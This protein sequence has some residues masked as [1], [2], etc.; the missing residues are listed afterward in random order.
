M[1]EALWA[2]I[3]ELRMAGVT[4]AD[5]PPAAFVNADKHAELSALLAATRRTWPIATSPTRPTSTARRSRH[6]DVW[7]VLA[8]D[9][10]IELPGVIW[11]PLERRLL[12]ALPGTRVTPR[13]LELPGLPPIVEPGGAC[14]APAPRSR[15][16]AAGLS[17]AARRGAGPASDGTLTMFRAGGREAEV[18][19]VLR[20]VLR[21][22]RPLDHVEIACARPSTWRWCGRRRSATSGRSRS[23]PACRSRSRGRRGRCWRSATGSRAGSRPARCG[24]CS[25]RA[26]CGS[27]W[28]MAPAPGRRRGSWRERRRRGDGRPTRRRS[29]AWRRRPGRGRGRGDGR[30][31]RQ[32]LRERA[33]Q[34]ERLA[35]WLDGLLRS[36]PEVRDDAIR[37]VA[38]STPHRLRADVAAQGERAGRRGRRRARRGAGVAAGAR[39]PRAVAAG[40]ARRWSATAST[41]SPS[42]A[43]ARGPGIS[44]SRRCAT[45]ATRAPAHL[46]HRARGRARV[47]GAAGGPVLLDA[48]R[49]ALDPGA[50]DLAGSRERGAPPRRLAAGRAGRPRL[51]ELFVSRSAR[52]PRDVS[53]L[54]D[55]AGGAP[56]EA[57]ARL[58]VRREL[59]DELGEPVSAVP[60]TAEQAL[61]D[62]GLVARPRPRAGRSALP[63]VRAAFP[64]AGAGR[65]GR[66][67]ARVG[68]LHRLRRLRARGGAAARSARVR[69]RRVGDGARGP[70]RSARSAT[71]CSAGSASTRSRTPSRI[72]DAGSIR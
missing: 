29:P 60:A 52:A 32:R 31:E 20:R 65:G 50:A 13:A 14:R 68:R 3:A 19:E 33:G 7:P 69:P 11:S 71:S 24:G 59:D 18:E 38:G 36:V 40:G 27:T 17:A 12:D 43:T 4:A 56:A 10:R 70:G 67:R 34:A 9:L 16:G 49:E 55:A 66:G 62:D 54:A 2:T 35:Q 26:T 53:L 8:G 47:P 44:T 63:A 58:D 51:P 22:G 5:L 37:W 64:C 46:R 72:R 28:T 15:R 42:A 39:R 21:D 41:A 57:R 30:R 48:E 45:R 25:S 1:A 23:A 6:L 61:S